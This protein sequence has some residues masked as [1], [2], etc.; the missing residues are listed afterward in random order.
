MVL[1]KEAKDLDDLVKTD[2]KEAKRVLQEPIPVYDFFFVTALKKHDKN[3][4]LGKKQ[5]MEDLAQRYSKITNPVVL[6]HY[7]KK[8]SEELGISM[9]IAL[10]VMRSERKTSDE[11]VD[12]ALESSS[13]VFVESSRHAPESYLLALILKTDL[14]IAG[15]FVYNLEPEDI[16]N[17]NIRE[18]FNL[19]RQKIDKKAKKLDPSKFSAEIEKQN[20][21][22]KKM[23]LDL[24]L[25]D[26]GGMTDDVSS[27]TK[28]LNA[29]ISRIKND[30]IKRQLN[31]LSQQIKLAEVEN[32]SK[33]LKKL[34]LQF[35]ELS[36]KLT[37]A[38]SRAITT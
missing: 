5:I 38:H 23:F 7:V 2:P 22:L 33:L 18:L 28:E 25:W 15:D 36:Q 37:E 20:P 26:F 19:I 17:E 3:T 32:N 21:D 9:E 27:L 16:Q 29:V 8:I 11:E 13:N 1:P 31:T 6:D 4:A 14:D 35:N 24:Y 10:S 30:S 34:T 12:R